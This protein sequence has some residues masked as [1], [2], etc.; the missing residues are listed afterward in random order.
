VE[1]PVALTGAGRR[2]PS[3]AT[4]LRSSAFVAAAVLSF[5]TVMLLAG[6]DQS[7]P[8]GKDPPGGRPTTRPPLH[9]PLTSASKVD[10]LFLIDDSDSMPPWQAK[11][12]ERLPNFMDVL[13]GAPG[14]MPDMH[15]AVVSSSLG[16]GIF[17]NVTG[18]VPGLAGDRDG[19]FQHKAGCGLRAGETFLASTGGENPINNFDGD[20]ADVFGCIAD[21][22][23]DGCWFEHQLEATRLALQKATS[24]GAG[25]NGF[26]RP[27]ALLSVI[28][29]TDED[30]CSAPA[31]SDLFDPSQIT[32]GE[33]LGGLQSYRCNEFGHR[34]RPA[35]P[36]TAPGTPVTMTECRSAEDGR[37][38]DVGAF[39]D[40]LY[41]LK[42]GTP[43]NVFVAV[44]AGPTM[45]YV[46]QSRPFMLANGGMEN[47][48]SV[49]HSCVVGSLGT[50]YADPAVR[51]SEVVEAFAPNSAF[52]SI[53]A[54]DFTNTMTGIAQQMVGQ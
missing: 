13:R 19:N 40:F 34:C 2:L 4:M 22:G 43:E 36:H 39:I 46:V 1:D 44:I 20:I 21:L 45:P 23:Q 48:P 47:Q 30:D 26:L 16:A 32:T 10:M 29:L 54:E 53:C 5:V 37:L 9:A 35:L 33:P 42:P 28:M 31:D 15:V 41:S 12:R 14:G 18:C 50:L 3:P 7:G 51:L 25:N 17:S 52:T 49:A 24:S 8:P 6:C 27:D 38:V 11:L